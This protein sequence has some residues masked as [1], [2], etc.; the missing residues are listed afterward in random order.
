MNGLQ[1]LSHCRKQYSMEEMPILI[2]TS[3]SSLSY[4]QLAKHLGANDYLTK[5]FLDQD[6][7]NSLQSYLPTVG[8]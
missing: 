8:G 1:F 3:R 6:L 7:I 4:R 2:L 5:P